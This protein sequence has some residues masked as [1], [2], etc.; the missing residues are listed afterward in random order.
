M[1]RTYDLDEASRIAESL[2]IDFAKSAFDLEQFCAGLNVEAEHG[3]VEPATNVT[4]DDPLTT[5]KIALAHLNELPDYYTRLR[6]METDAEP[7]KALE[8][9]S[10]VTARHQSLGL[11]KSGSI[12]LGLLALGVLSLRLLRK[13]GKSRPKTV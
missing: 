11:L 6:K 12:G 3:E 5:G 8:V 13:G 9:T 2:Q 1:K 10:K 4:N 7:A